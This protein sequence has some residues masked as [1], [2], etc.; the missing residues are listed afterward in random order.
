[1]GE[2]EGGIFATRFSGTLSSAMVGCLQLCFY[3]VLVHLLEFLHLFKHKIIFHFLKYQ[4]YGIDIV[5]RICIYELHS[6][7]KTDTEFIFIEKMSRHTKGIKKNK[8]N[9]YVSTSS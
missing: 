6:P 2:T 3:M 9:T 8:M 4:G 1:V 7:K 5:K